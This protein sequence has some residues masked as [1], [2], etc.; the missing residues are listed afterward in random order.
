[1]A[2]IKIPKNKE[3]KTNLDL[4][5]FLD[6]CSIKKYVN[7]DKAI[8][9]IIKNNLTSAALKSIQRWRANEKIG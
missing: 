5:V 8:A 3:K 7:T 4:L 2:I 9:K 6:G 1:M